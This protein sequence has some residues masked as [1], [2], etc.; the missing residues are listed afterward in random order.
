MLP[1]SGGN[2][3]A[4]KPPVAVLHPGAPRLPS[5][6]GAH[7]GRVLQPPQIQPFSPVG[8]GVN[9]SSS[10]YAPRLV[11]TVQPAVGM[12]RSS[13]TSSLQPQS[14]AAREEAEARRIAESNKQMAEQAD[15]EAEKTHIKTHVGA[16]IGPD[17]SFP[18]GRYV[19]KRLLGKGV[20]GK[21]LQCADLKWN[22]CLVAVK[23][24][25]DKP[26]Y[27]KAG[28]N[29]IRVLKTLGGKCGL[30]RLCRDFTHLNHV[31][32]STDLYGESLAQKLERVGTLT[33][34]QAADVSLQLLHGLQHMHACGITHTDM[35]TDNVLVYHRP[36]PGDD[37]SEI[38]DPQYPLAV[39]IVDVGSAC[40]DA[41]WHQP[42]IGTNEYRSPEAVLQ[43]GWS[44]QAD[45]WAVG[46]I[47][48]ELV[49]GKKLF[50]ELMSDNVHLLLM[51]RCLER[52]L[53]QG[54]LMKAWQKGAVRQTK[55]I[56]AEAQ[57]ASQKFVINPIC[58]DILQAK[59]LK[60]GL[61]VSLQIS[62]S[63]LLDLLDKLLEFDPVKRGNAKELRE[64]KFFCHAR[65]DR[66]NLE[67][68]EPLPPILPQHEEDDQAFDPVQVLAQASSVLSQTTLQA[69]SMLSQAAAGDHIQKEF[70]DLDSVEALDEH[71][72]RLTRQKHELIDQ[73]K[74]EHSQKTIKSSNANES[75]TQLDRL[76]SKVQVLREMRVR[77][78]NERQI[79]S[80][81]KASSE[82][83]GI[84]MSLISENL[85]TSFIPETAYGATF[86]GVQNCMDEISLSRKGSNPPDINQLT[87]PSGRIQPLRT[88]PMSPLGGGRDLFVTDDQQFQATGNASAGRQAAV[89]TPSRH[90]PHVSPFPGA[91]E[92][93][94]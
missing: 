89:R 14:Q 77:M 83:T 69:K 66:S 42:L 94:L 23:V 72:L 62:D 64:H 68:N 28:L 40:F 50:G 54:L 59:K 41:D 12:P 31:C 82:Q 88:P 87:P 56:F 71:L 44:H 45:V 47:L 80:G 37:N 29:E 91:K 38:D 78:D 60:D 79:R 51:E 25:R 49:T 24:V 48:V 46:C 90:D 21:V 13:S 73:L 10:F 55:V 75:L 1:N 43:S 53:P 4:S 15:A 39:R 61:P 70:Q 92:L 93:D 27:R 17:K 34:Q 20:Y 84:R 5:G 81:S 57:G 33:M 3:F 11:S 52:K 30:L 76:L 9:F 67:T 26:E 22:S 32:I 65:F 18:K 2:P 8:Y 86:S 19:V 58:S 6:E 74:T 36:E 85:E 63:E 16:A 7:H 35:K